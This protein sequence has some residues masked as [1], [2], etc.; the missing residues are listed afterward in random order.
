VGNKHF[1]TCYCFG[2]VIRDCENTPFMKHLK[3]LLVQ[4]G[5]YLDFILGVIEWL[6][7]SLC[8]FLANDKIGLM[9]FQNVCIQNIYLEGENCSINPLKYT[10]KWP[11]F[12]FNKYYLHLLC[13]KLNVIGFYNFLHKFQNTV[14]TITAEWKLKNHF[15]DLIWILRISLI[16]LCSFKW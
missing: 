8:H 16:T 1:L 6:D 9:I 4:L 7:F 14:S 5:V 15:V 3:H 11:S 12:L 10:L 2:T 13:L